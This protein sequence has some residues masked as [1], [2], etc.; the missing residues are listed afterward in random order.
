MRTVRTHTWFK[1]VILIL[2]DQVAIGIHIIEKQ[3]SKSVYNEVLLTRFNVCWYKKKKIK[4][5]YGFS[6]Y[7]D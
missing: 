6:E 2:H 7:N 5:Y 4:L 1:I 3:L